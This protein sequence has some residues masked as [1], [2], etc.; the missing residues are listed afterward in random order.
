[1]SALPLVR[2]QAA[3]RTAV[4]VSMQRALRD[5]CRQALVAVGQGLGIWLPRHWYR[6]MEIAAM[7]GSSIS[8]ALGCRHRPVAVTSV[9]RT[10]VQFQRCRR[11][12]IRI[13]R[14]QAK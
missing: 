1:M 10:S 5:S 13:S 7:G 14:R 11:I 3:R 6:V 8:P 9:R 2:F 4:R 12:S